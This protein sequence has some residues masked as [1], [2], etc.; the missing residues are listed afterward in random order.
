MEDKMIPAFFA[1]FAAIY[2][3]WALTPDDFYAS[4]A[5]ES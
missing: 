3:P 4:N 1:A 5:D 2:A